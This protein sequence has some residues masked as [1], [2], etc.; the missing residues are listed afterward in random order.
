MEHPYSPVPLSHKSARILSL[1]F[2]RFLVFTFIVDHF[3]CIFD[4]VDYSTAGATFQ[5]LTKFSLTP[6]SETPGLEGFKDK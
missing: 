1:L 3:F 6:N 4:S 2:F 5:V